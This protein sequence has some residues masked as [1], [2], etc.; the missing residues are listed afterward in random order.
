[1]VG[2]CY[3]CCNL[4]PGLFLVYP[5][6]GWF[7]LSFPRFNVEFRSFSPFLFFGQHT[8][9]GLFV[10]G[11]ITVLFVGARLIPYIGFFP[12][13]PSFFLNKTRVLQN[14]FPTLKKN[15]KGPH[16]SGPLLSDSPIAP[17]SHSYHFHPNHMTPP[18]SFLNF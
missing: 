18:S 17:I 3:N 11:I 12:K 15:K 5:R 8:R 14:R 4:I 16:K 2:G 13:Q 1:M 9:A 6:N 10:F 7:S